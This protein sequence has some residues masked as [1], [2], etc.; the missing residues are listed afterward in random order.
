[1]VWFA[2][3]RIF[4]LAAFILKNVGLI[5]GIAE[6]L[7]K[8]A[9]GIIHLTPTR[10]D[11]GWIEGIKAGANNIQ[12]WLYNGAET[13]VNFYKALGNWSGPAGGRPGVS[14]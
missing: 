9:I 2:I 1:M 12:G 5:V 4:W 11:D 14:S 6:Q 13:I 10:K 7:V 8:V 3:T